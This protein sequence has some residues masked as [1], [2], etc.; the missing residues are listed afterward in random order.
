MSPFEEPKINK[1]VFQSELEVL[2]CFEMNY[3]LLERH[4][5]PLS[6]A[7]TRKR[8]N[9]LN[10]AQKMASKS[11]TEQDEEATTEEVPWSIVTYTEEE[12]HTLN[13]DVKLSVLSLE[14]FI[15][16]NFATK[17]V[18]SLKTNVKKSTRYK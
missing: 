13:R 16:F 8:E 10:T 6:L 1:S 4:K 15:S 11:S 2:P 18:K 7:T 9:P 14:H 17:E 5:K 3:K 12:I